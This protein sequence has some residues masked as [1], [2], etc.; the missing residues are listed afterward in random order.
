MGGIP[1][2]W[3]YKEAEAEGLPQLSHFPEVGERYSWSSHS[4]P[5]LSHSWVLLFV[6]WDR[7]PSSESDI[8]GAG[9][10]F[11]TPQLCDFGQVT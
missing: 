7:A 9:L 3:G 2:R 1:D 5:E 4:R 11:P 10:G 6:P 8:A